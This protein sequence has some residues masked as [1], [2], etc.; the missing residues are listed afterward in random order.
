MSP[1]ISNDAA[2]LQLDLLIN[3]SVTI[4]AATTET[5]IATGLAQA[6]VAG[7]KCQRAL[8]VRMIAGEG[9]L[10][11]IGAWPSGA[12]SM[13]PIS[14][15]LIRGASQGKPVRLGENE[16]FN[17][18]QSIVGSGVNGAVCI[19]IEI[20]KAIEGFLYLDEFPAKTNYDEVLSFSHAL[21]RWGGLALMRLKRS[22]LESRQRDLLEE[23][24]TARRVQERMMGATA[25]AIS[26]VKW[27][28]C[29]I[30][31]QVVAGDLFGVHPAVSGSGACIFLG[32]VSGKGLGPGLLMAAIT[33]HLEAQLA[34][35]VN[36]EKAMC[37]LSNFVTSRATSGQFA[38]LVMA[39]VSASAR[40]CN[41]FDAGHGYYVIIGRTGQA[42]PIRVEPGIPI[43]VIE[44]FLY[45]STVFP[46]ERGDRIVMFSDGLAEERDES[47]A[48]LGAERIHAALAGSLGCEE[49]VARLGE[50]LK[51][52]SKCERYAD[53]VTIASI[54][55]EADLEPQ[56]LGGG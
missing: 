6:C 21:C 47:G 41:L 24:A 20:D 45:E 42:K 32:D 31:G 51:G 17:A 28:M 52:F 1:P 38:T 56:T 11:V 10:E 33:A 37:D 43:G 49:D 55:L 35:G 44:G 29:S 27:A 4:Q 54:M 14:R 7:T 8:A 48:M 9:R 5:E 50:L 19:P 46:I 22:E 39:E 2:Q 18:A 12:E 36:A 40:T 3:T 25:G 13:R 16:S 30:P 53:D 15:T 23:L 34:A 26:D